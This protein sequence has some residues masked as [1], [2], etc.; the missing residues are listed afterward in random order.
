M[1]NLILKIKSYQEDVTY[2]NTEVQNN[3]SNEEIIAFGKE[4]KLLID[5]TIGFCEGHPNLIRF[6]NQDGIF[7]SELNKITGWR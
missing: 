4:M 5:N 1:K 3:L 7:G 6:E 2:I